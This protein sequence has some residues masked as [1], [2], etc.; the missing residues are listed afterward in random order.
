MH[1]CTCVQSGLV[2]GTHTWDG[3]ELRANVSVF[4]YLMLDLLH[5]SLFHQVIDSHGLD[6]PWLLHNAL[7][8]FSFLLM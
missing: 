7:K 3:R 1:M 8:S 6:V 4:R 2:V 5:A